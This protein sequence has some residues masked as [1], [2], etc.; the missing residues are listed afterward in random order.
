MFLLGCI[1]VGTGMI[2]RL[3]CAQ[4]IAG[5]KDNKLVR[6]G[7]YSMCRNPL[8]FF[9]FLG[10]IGVGFCTESIVLTAVILLFFVLVYPGVISSEEH[11]LSGLFGSDYA[12]YLREVPRFFPNF[13]LFHEPL[14]YTV[15]PKVF[16]QAARD[17]L[18]FIW[19]VGIF[20]A[21]EGAKLSGLIPALWNLF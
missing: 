1:L 5:Y 12:A 16:R 2:G 19:A 17:V 21:I 11:K 13:H 20:A 14:H 8:Y 6:E 15:N 18:W 9:S 4:Y 10:G 7:P 3:W